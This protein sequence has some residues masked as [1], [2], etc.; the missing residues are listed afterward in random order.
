MAQAKLPY[1]SE[2]WSDYNSGDSYRT[3]SWRRKIIERDSNTCKNC[4]NNVRDLFRK[5]ISSNE[6]HH[7]I[8]RAYGGKNTLNNGI[9]LCVFCHDY[10]HSVMS[11]KGIEYYEIIQDKQIDE[12]VSEVKKMLIRRYIKDLS[13]GLK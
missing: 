5:R 11:S 4:R 1:Y 9:T 8:P 2:P 3:A 13:R 6:A 10:F 12:R 7:I